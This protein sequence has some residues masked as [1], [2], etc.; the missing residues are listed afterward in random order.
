MCYLCSKNKGAD[1]LCDCTANLRLCY[2]IFKK[3]V[4]RV[5]TVCHFIFIFWRI[6]KDFSNQ[7]D[8]NE[9]IRCLHIKVIYFTAK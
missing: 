1:Q 7:G 8:Y 4:L 9:S 5:Y 3:L 2:C 6:Q